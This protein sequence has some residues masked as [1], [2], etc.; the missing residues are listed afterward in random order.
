MGL[1]L[2]EKKY[3]DV[4]RKNLNNSISFKRFL[5]AVNSKVIYYGWDYFIVS[6][7][8]D[9]EVKANIQKDNGEIYYYSMFL[10]KNSV[11]FNNFL[12]NYSNNLIYKYK[13]PFTIDFENISLNFKPNE[14]CTSLS[15]N[16]NYNRDKKVLNGIEELALWKFKPSNY[17]LK[18]NR[19]KKNPQYHQYWFNTQM[20]PGYVD[21]YNSAYGETWREDNFNKDNIL[22]GHNLYCLSNSYIRQADLSKNILNDFH[23]EPM[24]PAHGTSNFN[25]KSKFT[26]SIKCN[27][28][29]L[30]LEN[31]GHVKK[32]NLLDLKRGVWFDDK[33]ILGA[34]LII[35][36]S[37][38]LNTFD[39]FDKKLNGRL[40]R[41][42]IDKSSFQYDIDDEKGLIY[43]ARLAEDEF[44]NK[45][46]IVVSKFDT[47]HDKNLKI[48][49]TVIGENLLVGKENSQKL[50]SLKLKKL[51]INNKGNVVLFIEIN[52]ERIKKLT[53]KGYYSDNY[54][55]NQF[56]ISSTMTRYLMIELDQT[57]NVLEK[58]EYLKC[59]KIL[60][61]ETGGYYF[62]KNKG[63]IV[64]FI[65]DNYSLG[66][67]LDVSENN[68]RYSDIGVKYYSLK[69]ILYVATKSKEGYMLGK[70]S[71]VIYEI[72]EDGKIMNK[73]FDESSNPT[74]IQEILFDN[75]KPVFYL[76]SD[77]KKGTLLKKYPSL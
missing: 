26:N 13:L 18:F 4:I 35:E 40:L 21:F 63:P 28:I 16:I 55:S 51:T 6:K 17:N 48:R 56:N 53:A 19:G 1:D 5:H 30:Y 62:I 33:S 31:N 47:K 39:Y 14:I 41:F 27:P 66:Y 37:Y 34:P 12:Y 59:D 42:N 44:W 67:E 64:T 36:N 69:G 7:H 15:S 20:Y 23:F 43:Y 9:I 38:K 76:I 72:D 45:K 71:G 52:S 24:N 3:F 65:K 10:E 46:H 70:Q 32:V 74:R 54:I 75:E 22:L 50:K 11:V 73:F 58:F 8:N 77:S 61:S 29:H 57:L 2:V 25:I 68:Q 60:V 49:E